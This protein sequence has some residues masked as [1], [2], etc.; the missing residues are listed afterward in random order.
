MRLIECRAFWRSTSRILKYRRQLVWASAGALVFAICFGTSLGILQSAVLLLLKQRSLPELFASDPS[1]ARF[2]SLV[3]P[4]W[5]ILPSEP[6]WQFTT[7]VGIALGL[8]VLSGA[9]RYLH[10]WSASWAIGHAL[11]DLRSELFDRQLRMP[12][13][14]NLQLSR[15]ERLSP[16][17]ADLEVLESTHTQLFVRAARHLFRG[18]SAFA[19]ALLIDARLSLVVLLCAPPTLVL[20]R[21]FDGLIR[22]ASADQ[23]AAYGGLLHLA[24]QSLQGLAIVKLHGTE[25]WESKRYDRYNTTICE[26]SLGIERLRLISQPF[27]ETVLLIGLSLAAVVAAWLV[28]RQSVDPANFIVVIVALVHAGQSVAPLAQL[29]HLVS[30]ADAAA[31]RVE[32]IL[33]LTLEREGPS[34]S[35]QPLPRHSGEIRFEDLSFSYRSQGPDVLSEVN[36]TV[37]HGQAVAIVG[38]NGSGKT[39]LM[40]MLPRLLKPSA[41]R[42]LIDGTDVAAADLHSLRAQ[43]AMVPQE[44]YLFAD[45]VLENIR[46]GLGETVTQDQVEE[47]AR[48]ARAHEFIVELAEGYRTQLGDGGTGLSAGQKQRLAIA[49][50]VLRDPAILILDEATSQI[51]QESEEMINLALEQLRGERTIFMVTHE[52]E[53]MISADLVVFLERGR[54]LDSGAHQELLTGSSRYQR[55][56]GSN[57]RIGFEVLG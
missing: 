55:L 16:I 15:A 6:F 29:S 40:L 52:K 45:S 9:G 51:D 30:E 33:S 39:T 10:E 53:R 41:G 54:I 44:S 17:F 49:R 42:V 35:T 13:L 8:G 27:V 1:I 48:V 23:L 56:V 19:V 36:L 31:E 12:L 38:G 21:R 18:L 57:R 4:L 14:L 47:A 20:L 28:F 32:D 24:Q 34:E 46:Y 43:I 25:N 5:G 3:V 11:R 50:A 37:H 26:K 2:E 22:H 7:V